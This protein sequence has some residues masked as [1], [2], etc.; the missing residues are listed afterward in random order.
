MING[1]QCI[2][3][4]RQD[5]EDYMRTLQ[6]VFLLAFFYV[7]AFTLLVE[8]RYEALAEKSSPSQSSEPVS[9]GSVELGH[10]ILSFASVP[11]TVVVGETVT[12]IANLSLSCGGG[13]A[14]P[15]VNRL[16]LFFPTEADCGVDIGQI[17]PD[18][19]WT[20]S[21]GNAE[22]RLVFSS[23]GLFG[24]RIK[25]RGE[26]KPDPCPA[27]GNNACNPQ[28]PNSNTR[29]VSLSSSNDCRIMAVREESIP[30]YIQAH[31]PVNLVVTDPE[32]DSIGVSFNT[33]SGATYTVYN[34]SIFI[35]EALLGNYG[36][37]AVLDTSDLSGDTSY[38]IEARID[39]TAD[40][41][42]A[43]SAP[44]PE[45]D[46][47]HYYVITSDPSM[48][49]CLS[50]P[51]DANGNGTLNLVDIISIVNYIFNHSGCKPG[52]DCWLWGLNCRGD[53]NGNGSITSADVVGGVNY[54]FGKPGGP[55]NPV[56]TQACCLPLF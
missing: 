40:Q 2:I 43:S 19:S 24:V 10:T 49:Q 21:L 42:L 35:A 8:G 54:I 31:S 47:A 9:R 38:A 41:T 11:D 30:I 14:A 25:F 39:G 55:W 36:I 5:E 4:Y 32:G 37:K 53:W 51:G 26:D 20:D 6:R 34:D 17:A 27:I 28:D 3:I 23:V 18:S 1:V 45:E 48:P 56:A 46:E 29:C 22:G 33:I 15:L 50:K 13:T 12:V 44:L 7:G 16:I 52:P